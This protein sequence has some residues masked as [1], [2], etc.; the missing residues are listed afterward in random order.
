MDNSTDSIYDYR[1]PILLMIGKIVKKF[2]SK[3]LPKDNV[4]SL[5]SIFFLVF[6]LTLL[7]AI[8]FTA[9]ERGAIVN[10][11]CGLFFIV[12]AIGAVFISKKNNENK[13]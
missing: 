7:V 11:T 12:S 4:F 6:G 8:F 9:T 5:I 1:L 2:I 3:Y 10:L 13:S